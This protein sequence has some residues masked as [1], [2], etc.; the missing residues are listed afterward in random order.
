MPASTS[1]LSLPLEDRPREKLE[2]VGPG[3]LT[4]M[5]LL[6]LILGVGEP[7]HGSALDL[8]GNL[9]RRFGDLAGLQQ[10]GLRELTELGGIGEGA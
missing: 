6:A 8:A 5:E 9:L 2:R 10:A 7:C 1:I 4:G 3:A